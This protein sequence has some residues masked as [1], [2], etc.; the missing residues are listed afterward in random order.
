MVHMSLYYSLLCGFE[1][2]LESGKLGYKWTTK[3]TFLEAL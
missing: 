1:A 3:I 2:H